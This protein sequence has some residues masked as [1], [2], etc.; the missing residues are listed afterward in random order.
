[1]FCKQTST[2]RSETCADMCRHEVL[3][4]LR[5]LN[6]YLLSKRRFEWLIFVTNW[7]LFETSCVANV[8]V[9]TNSGTQTLP[10]DVP[11]I[12]KLKRTFTYLRRSRFGA[13]KIYFQ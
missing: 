8:Y 13:I 10:F 7:G 4:I 2:V 9:A 11:D 1:M 6:I 3:F 12:L 5:R